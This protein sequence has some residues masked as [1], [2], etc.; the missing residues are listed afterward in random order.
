MT[1]DATRST[2]LSD[3]IEDEFRF[4]KTWM[5]SPLKMGAVS[6]TS[7][8]LARLMVETSTL[9]RD[10]YALELGPGTGVVT[11]A[12]L[13]WGM[14]AE[15]IVAVEYDKD[16]STLLRQRFPKV[17][18]INGD[19]L[20]LETTLGEFRTTTFSSVLSGVPILTLPKAKRIGYVEGAL[21]RAQPG[22]NMTQLSYS[23]KPPQDAVPGRFTVEKSKWIAFNLP[24]GRVWVYRRD[25]A[26]AN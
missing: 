14:P 20:D 6:P 21:D 18:I 23:L 8:A 9:D 15:R 13:E 4:F 7:R 26:A 22:G 3:R 11:E 25:P 16:F 12:M 5:T 24:P 17:N 19:A 1:R 2:T 10:G